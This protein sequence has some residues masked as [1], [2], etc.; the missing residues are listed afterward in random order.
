MLSEEDRGLGK[1]PH[2]K[3]HAGDAD[4]VSTDRDFGKSTA[5]VDRPEMLQGAPLMAKTFGALQVIAE[6]SSSF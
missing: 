1:R 4:A 5:F 6:A 3:G 2:I